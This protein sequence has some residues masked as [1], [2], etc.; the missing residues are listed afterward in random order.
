MTVQKQ[1]INGEKLCLKNEEIYSK[2]QKLCS[3]ADVVKWGVDKLAGNN[4]SKLPQDIP[5]DLKVTT[6]DD[7]VIING[8]LQDV[9]KLLSFPSDIDSLASSNSA[10]VSAMTVVDIGRTGLKLTTLKL[11]KQFRVGHYCK[12]GNDHFIVLQC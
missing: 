10:Y 11:Q 7:Y 4:L 8:H 3:L 9:F 2:D 5:V 1:K 12:F 6:D